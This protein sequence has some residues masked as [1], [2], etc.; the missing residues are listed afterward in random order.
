VSAG[1]QVLVPGAP[2]SGIAWDLAAGHQQVFPDLQR[3]LGTWL[4]GDAG[5]G[6]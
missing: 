3:G 2:F 5:N 6:D 1:A 4:G